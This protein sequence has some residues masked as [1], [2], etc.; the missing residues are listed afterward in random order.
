MATPI[1]SKGGRPGFKP[2][3]AMHQKVKQLAGRGLTQE[4]VAAAVGCS[5]PT[6]RKY[7]GEVYS[8]AFKSKKPQFEKTPALSE[9]VELYIGCGMK[10]GQIA[11]ALGCSVEV[12]RK[13]FGEELLNGQAKILA[14]SLVLL[15]DSARAGNVSAQKH[16]NGLA[17][18]TPEK[19]D[20]PVKEPALGKKVVAER[21][22]ASPPTADSGWDDL[23]GPSVDRPN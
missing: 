5:V 12:L 13:L 4:D 9:K 15:R 17:S 2:T 14:E 19:G 6:F 16:L 18:L 1:K 20:R 23:V 10:D 11:R 22:A 7:L 8:G 3:A 21:E